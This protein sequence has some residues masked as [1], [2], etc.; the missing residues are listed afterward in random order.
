VS[1]GPVVTLGGQSYTLPVLSI[2]KARAFRAKIDG[3][4]GTL[5]AALQAAPRT[6]V[7]DLAAVG[8]LLGAVQE[9]LL[10]S[11]DL[12][13]ELLF[14]YSDEL[15]ADRERIEA[16][17]TDEEALAAFVEVMRLVYPFAGLVSLVTGPASRKT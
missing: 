7:S 5:V 13:V 2:R 11:V 15:A 3:P 1:G 10:G 9:T 14:A 16:E 17:A 6:E 4:V 12:V 8:G